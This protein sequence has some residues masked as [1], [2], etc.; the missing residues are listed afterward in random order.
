MGPVD[1]AVEARRNTQLVGASPSGILGDVDNSGQ[2]DITDGLL[3]AA[4]SV[5]AATA[6]PNNGDIARGDVNGD[7][8]TD[9][10]DAWLLATYKGD[11]AALRLSRGARG[12]AVSTL[13][14]DVLFS[15]NFS[16]LNQWTTQTGGSGSIEV[17]NGA[18]KLV[19]TTG[20]DYIVKVSKEIFPTK[21][22]P[23]YELSF[24]WKSTVKET[25]DGINYVSATFYNS[26]NTYL[27]TLTAIHTV[28][29]DWLIHHFGP[30]NVDPGRYG[31]R[32]KESG[33][34]G[35]ERVTIN[36][37]PATPLINTGD[38]HK[39][40]V[41]VV[42]SNSAGSGGD[43]YVDNLSFE[44]N[45]GKIYWADGSANKIQRANLDGSQKQDLVTG[46][47]GV[48]GFALDASGGKMY[49]TER[50]ANKIRRAN[51]DG[52]QVQDVVT[53]LD[54][55][56]GLTLDT[57]G[58]KI[59]W[60]DYNR[61]KIQRS[62]LDG[63]QVQDVVTGLER[64]HELALDVSG[65]KIYW[66][67][68]SQK[69]QRSNLD[70][71]QVQDLVTK[72]GLLHGIALD[73]SGGK[74]YWVD[75]THSRIRRSNLD[76]SQVQDVVTGLSAPR[77]IALSGGKMYW[78]ESGSG[79]IRRSNLDGSQ[80]Q[81]VVTGLSAPRG[82]ALQVP[83]QTPPPP[84]KPDLVVTASPSESRVAS[85]DT[86]TLSSTV[87]NQGTAASASTTV[88]YYRSSDQN[89]STSDTE[90]GSSSVSGLDAGGS[91]RVSTTVTALTVTNETTY[92]YGA[93][94]QSV[95][96]ESNTNNNCSTGMSVTVVPPS[97]V[98]G[99]G[100]SGPAG[101]GG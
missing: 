49:W 10:T 8:Q 55:P 58:S 41:E 84:G 46:L 27:G 13:S 24:D 25:P 89:I 17:E 79:K 70:G 101:F 100:S 63:S 16:N 28:Y 85:G 99:A 87:T 45:S 64:P 94:V 18:L 19:G 31:G 37:S 77:S 3:V 74:I 43:L 67:G 68:N 95:S 75:Y 20:S 12:K 73:V 60:T 83:S 53:G 2:V 7:N 97:S 96:G 86:F 72:A 71:S 65:G 14:S 47:E 50:G 5:N 44:G 26:S 82:I 51:L 32:L 92:Y 30:P 81:D 15:D 11:L 42:V 4:Y 57:S 1:I 36:T 98:R 54:E 35:W 23:N 6:L 76:G 80:V 48:D 21:T 40:V 66:V 78:T 62:N 39:I 34:F 22:Y 59:Y 29:S 93:C 9:I 38:V 91:A 90:Q 56:I 52:S 88:K 61:N 69:V 33:P